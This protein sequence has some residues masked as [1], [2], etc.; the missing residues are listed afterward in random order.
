MSPYQKTIHTNGKQ[1]S[2]SIELSEVTWVYAPPNAYSRL[3]RFGL[4]GKVLCPV[5]VSY[6]LVNVLYIFIYKQMQLHIEHECG[7]NTGE[8][9]Q[10]RRAI[11]T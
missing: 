2:K 1:A 6:C 5:F 4:K 10:H 11:S 3:C 8:G 7:H 9:L